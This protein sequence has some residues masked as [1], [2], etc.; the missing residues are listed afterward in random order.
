MDAK[1][2][3]PFHDN[4]CVG[5]KPLLHAGKYAWCERWVKTLARHT[6]P[7]NGQALNRKRPGN[8]YTPPKQSMQRPVTDPVP[9]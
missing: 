2:I 4:G 1:G 3:E 7:I 9:L 6:Q 8:L 5:V